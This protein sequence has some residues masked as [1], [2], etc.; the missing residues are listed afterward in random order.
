MVKLFFIVA[1]RNLCREKLITAIQLAGLAIGIACFMLIRLYVAHEQS[2]NQNFSQAENIYRLDLIR[3]QNRPQALTPLRLGDELS[4]NF[5]DILDSTRISRSRVSVKHQQGVYSERVQYVDSNYFEFFDFEFIEGDPLTAMSG[6]SSIVLPQEAAIKYFAADTGI[7]GKTLTV[8]GVEF[9]V[10]GVVKKPAFAHTMSETVLLPGERFNEFALAN[11]AWADSWTFNATVTFVKLAPGAQVAGLQA[12]ISD[13]YQQRAQGLSSYKSYRLNLE[14]MTKLHL[15]TDTSR[16][17]IPQGSGVMVTAF[18]IIAVMILLLACVNF[19]NLAT[20]SAMR[21]GKDVGVRKSLGASKL[22]LVVQYLSEAVLQTTLAGLLALVLVW[23]ALPYFNQLME[24]NL[25]FDLGAAVLAQLLVL[26]SIVG[27]VAGLYPAFYL[28]NLSPALVLKG[29]VNSS[30]VGVML[31]QGLIVFQFAIA[32]LLLV[33]SLG[34]NWQMSYI[35]NM[36]QGYDREGVIVIN[37]GAD[38][39]NTFKNQLLRNPQVAA[40]TMSHT[41]PTKATRTSNVVRRAD[42]VD[43][44][45]Q[46]GSN[47]VSYDFFA[48]YGI[49]I[50]A[51]RDFSRDFSNDAYRENEQDWKSSTGSIIINETLATALGWGA[52]QAVGK[53]LT[54][55][56]GDDGLHNHQVIAVVED[57]HYISVKTAVPAMIYVL[58]GEPQELSLRWLSVRFKEGVNASLL[59]EL[60][61]TWLSLSPDQAFTFD[62]IATEFASLYRN[63]S[64]QSQLLNVFT[65]IAV[66][67]TA[68]GLFGL[69]AFNTRRRV[70]EIAI[71]KIL[72]AGTAQLCFMLVNQFSVLVVLANVLVL[73]LAYWLLR[74]WLNGFIYRIDMPYSPFVLSTLFSLLVAYVTV[75]VIAYRAANATPVDALQYE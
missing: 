68:I 71:R 74:D 33:A 36:P 21:R 44:E 19:T 29:V 58:S 45:I 5:D 56:G 62:W 69:A 66:V 15:Y 26:T 50:L 31:R 54:L 72:G 24:V 18:S 7:I 49:K 10:T 48:T 38:I 59:G 64:R 2:Y 40:V 42:N 27:V 9:Q 46:V 6:P 14:A 47:P 65:L 17:L 28:S 63:E 13:Y 67:V 12:N 57:S 35:Q 30:P 73:P 1:W 8:N 20:A 75:M 51:G 22:Q 23:G 53:M 39:Y 16:T 25:S 61:Q 32:A 3:D 11:P 52:D 70:K 4:Q 34:V 55:G 43:D 60:E 37:G 41:V